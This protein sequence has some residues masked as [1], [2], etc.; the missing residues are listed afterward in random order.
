MNAKLSET[1]TQLYGEKAQAVADRCT[2]VDPWFGQYVQRVIYDEIWTLPPLS[3]PE[4]SMIT[5]VC[6]ATLNKE[7]QLHIHLQ[8]YLNLGG[9]KQQIDHIFDYLLQ[10]RYIAKNAASLTVLQTMQIA[11]SATTLAELD[12]SA[13]NKALI[14]V[15]CHATLG[16]N[17]NTKACL[18]TVLK[19]NRL[20]EDYIRGVL[21]QI[22]IYAGCPAAMNSFAL[23]TE[24]KADQAIYS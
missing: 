9:T 13:K 3:L 19:E 15:A 21:R 5:V 7:E 6:L 23:L 12:L 1:L 11:D 24:I 22:M 14:D 17:A 4:K 20:A 8:G 2:E 16:N 18:Q 10:H